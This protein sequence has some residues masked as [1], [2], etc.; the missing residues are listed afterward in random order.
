MVTIYVVALGNL[1]VIFGFSI[2]FLVFRENSFASATIKVSPDQRLVST[3][4]Y[5]WVRHPMYASVLVTVLGAPLALGSWW[6]G[7]VLIPLI[8]VIT[9]RLIAEEEFLERDL[10]GYRSYCQRVSYRLFPGVW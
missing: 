2:R 4:P 6:G 5:A 8:A 10:S 3:G 1:L 9:W 7:I